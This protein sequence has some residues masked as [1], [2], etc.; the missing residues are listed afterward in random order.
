MRHTDAVGKVKL[1]DAFTSEGSQGVQ[2]TPRF[3]NFLRRATR[4]EHAAAENSA[5]MRALFN[6]Q[7]GQTG[8]VN[9]LEGY[10]SLYSSWEKRYAIW[11]HGIH[12]ADGW[13]Y[14]TRLRAIEYDLRALGAQ[15]RNE[16]SDLIWS[17]LDTL[18][19][20]QTTHTAWGSLYVIEGSALGGQIIARKLNVEFPTMQH[21]FFFIGCE[22]ERSTWKD[23]QCLLGDQLHS[24]D[25]RRAIALQ[26]RVTFGIFQHMLDGVRR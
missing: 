25:S 14:K 22:A 12:E 6:K 8:Y 23:F 18:D 15:P 11:L 5:V 21:R 9:L 16:S 24:A 13:F 7:L 10:H 17:A 20:P 1:T 4:V 2:R 19:T 3:R 26:A